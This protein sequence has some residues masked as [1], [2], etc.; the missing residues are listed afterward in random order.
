MMRNRVVTGVAVVA[1]VAA[2]GVG[3]ALIGVPG[4]SSASPF[5][6][7]ATATAA[8]DSNG[9]APSMRP[10][11]DPA[12]LDAAAKALNLTTQQ[13]TD[14][15]SDGKTTIADVA[16]QQKVDLKTVVDAMA[17]AD[18]DR[19]DKIVNEPWPNFGRGQHGLGGAAFGGP[20]GPFMR[21]GFGKFS[22]DSLAKA[23]GI[24][25]KE[26]ETDLGK[27][28]SIADI[29]KAKNVDLNKVI[30]ALVADANAKIDQAQKDGHLSKDAATKAKDGIKSAITGFVNNGFAK[31]AMG[32]HF[33]FGGPGRGFGG[34][35]MTPPTPA[36]P[37]TPKAPSA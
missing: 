27:G 24:T 33:R 14:K 37:T 28:Q 2:G 11:G 12:L 5:P 4:L 19:I 34:P 29:A 3:G 15:L 8:A 6:Q 17:G 9:K 32:G 30:D 23:L 25:T 20:G 13:L 18:R 16:K 35:M 36:T 1:A 22:S 7:Q 21:G 31:G 26:L 10:M